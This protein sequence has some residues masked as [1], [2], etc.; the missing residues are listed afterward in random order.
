ML[1]ESQLHQQPN[2]TNSEGESNVLT[3]KDRELKRKQILKEKGLRMKLSPNK[4]GP[5]RTLNL[6][7]DG[8]KKLPMGPNN[9]TSESRSEHCSKISSS[10]SST[11]RMGPVNKSDNR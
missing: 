6:V 9:S 3:F 10:G 11:A 7:M 4:K 2:I 8:P 5:I 1:F